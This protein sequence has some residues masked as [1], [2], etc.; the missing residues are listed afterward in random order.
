MQSGSQ[1]A[2]VRGVQEPDRLGGANR[3]REVVALVAMLVIA[4]GGC[5]AG[6][7]A[8]LTPSSPVELQRILAV[9]GLTIAAVLWFAPANSRRSLQHLGCVVTLSGTTALISQAATAVGSATSTLSYLWVALYAAGFYS[10]TT[11]RAYTLTAALCCAI[12]VSLNPYPGMAQT[13]TL[14]LLTMAVSAEILGGLVEQLRRQSSTDHLTGALNRLGLASA[15]ED[16]FRQTRQHGR[17]AVACVFDLDGFKAVN[18][19]GGHAAGDALLREFARAL[20]A[21]VG[22]GDV[23]ARI[24]GDEFV[25]LLADAEQGFVGIVNSRLPRNT[26][27]AWS[28]GVATTDGT[29]SLDVVLDRAD[30]ALYVRKQKRGRIPRQRSEGVWSNSPVH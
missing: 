7:L 18:D 23:V 29:E 24:G 17:S 6:A 3:P 25:V 12:G 5:A 22:A 4:A 14:I 28:Y 1:D 21:E 20:Q 10:R 8:P 11:A 15:S 2:E 9:V 19:A 26:T 30:S 16:L 13:A 27:A